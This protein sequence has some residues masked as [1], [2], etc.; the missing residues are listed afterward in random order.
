MTTT[1][2]ITKPAPA[3]PVNVRALGLRRLVK[4]GHLSAR[5]ALDLLAR[6]R[7]E[8]QYVKAEI[9]GWLQRKLQS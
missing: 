2:T 4:D 3:A 9:I 6:K 8:G 1:T 5:E 7:K